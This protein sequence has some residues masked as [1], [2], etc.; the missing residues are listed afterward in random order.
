MNTPY[1]FEKDIEPKIDAI[2]KK[3]DDAQAEISE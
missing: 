2:E 1:T 3:F